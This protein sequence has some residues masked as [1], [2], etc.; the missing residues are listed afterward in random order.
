MEENTETSEII[1]NIENEKIIKKIFNDFYMSITKDRKLTKENTDIITKYLEEKNYHN[2]ILADDLSLDLRYYTTKKERIDTKTNKTRRT[3]IILTKT[4]E[5]DTE[6]TKRSG[7]ANYIHLHD[8]T[9]AR[10][11][12]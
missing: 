11:V 5:I 1:R 10:D 3:K 9:L 12:A 8:S 4:D 2:I 7:K 6:K